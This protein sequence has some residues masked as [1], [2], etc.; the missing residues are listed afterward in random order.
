MIKIGKMRFMAQCFEV[1]RSSICNHST[2]VQHSS[3]DRRSN[4][5]DD[6][7]EDDV[8]DDH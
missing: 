3:H 1:E 2:V 7:G 5:N 8:Y 6:D 4:G